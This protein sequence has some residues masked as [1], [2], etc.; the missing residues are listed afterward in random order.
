MD[1]AIIKSTIRRFRT[2]ITILFL[3]FTFS[4]VSA[5]CEYPNSAFSAGESLDFDLY[6][7]WKFVWVKVGSTHYKITHSTYQGK[8]ALRT[9]LIFKS[10]KACDRFFP[11]RDTLVS[12]STDKLVPLYFRKGANEGK[13]YTVDE[14]WYSYPDNGK[15]V[16]KMRYK[17]PDDE[18]TDKTETSSECI[19]DMLNIL[20]LSRSL[21]FSNYKSGQRTTYRM[22]TGKRI[23][24]QILIYK[25]KKNFKANDDKTYRCLVFSLLNDKLKDEKELLRFYITDD[26]NH[27]PVRIDFHLNFGEAVAKFK[28][29]SGIRN[30]QTSII[31]D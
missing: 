10:N 11:M 9:D 27:L 30:K 28:H 24:N 4:S 26:R 18:W 8:K 7:N 22:V 5:Q 29:G 23:S 6:F 2:T 3:L 12:Y 31:K 20:A 19:N 1:Q 21:D 17:D 15:T 14:V 13:R 25:G 16:M